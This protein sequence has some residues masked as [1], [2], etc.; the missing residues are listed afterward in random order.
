MNLNRYFHTVKHLKPVQIKYQVKYR[1]HPFSKNLKKLNSF[2]NPKTGKS[3]TF[4][5]WTVKPVSYYDTF[6]FEF[7]NKSIQYDNRINWTDERYGKLW[8]YNLNYMD[9]LLQ[10]GMT[11]EKGVELINLFI[12]SLSQ[13]TVGIEPYPI[14]LRG[15]N[16]IKFLSVNNIKRQEIDRSLYVQYKILADNLEYH[17][18]GNHLLENGFSLLFGAYYFKD[19]ELYLKAKQILE[20]ELEE[21]ILSDGGHFELSPMY[22]QIILDRL[23][24]SINLLQN[25]KRFDD[26]E[27]LLEICKTKARLMIN[28]LEQMTFSNGDIPHF[29]DS[30]DGI[31]PSSHQI[32]EYAKRLDSP[33]L[34]L[35]HSLFSP[36]S[37]S[38]YRRYNGMNYEAIIDIGEIGPSYQPG[39][40]HADTFN[41]VLNVKNEPFIVDTGIST[42]NPGEVRL[43]ERGTAAHNTVTVADK[44]SS[45]VWSSFRVARRAKVK[46]LKENQQT[47]V[48]SHDGYKRF[49]TI[50]Q[51]GWEFSENQIQIK[52]SLN[53]KITEGKA[54]FWLAPGLI[55]IKEGANKIKINNSRLEFDNATGIK[56]V[57]TKI[58]NGYNR[59]AENFK[60]EIAFK[61]HLNTTITTN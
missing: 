6:K 24:D 16:W 3:L 53:G 13:N 42:Y 5:N 51:C 2:K 52:D 7:L 11:V 48:A 20:K 57:K 30:T 44:D 15:I 8:A 29:N 58:P 61:E 50:H 54:F 17:L 32:F 21:Q 60:I 37:A 25:N 35:S 43:K 36:L 31:A 55:P 56:I 38:G 33:L 41:F 23:L 39:H 47:I 26:Q 27:E 46:I 59:F 4:I 34:S 45:E 1:L 10:P 28:W 18:L 49:G 19:E 40:A 9:Y 12:K 22:H 14:S